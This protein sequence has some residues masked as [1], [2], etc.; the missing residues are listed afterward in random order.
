MSHIHTIM[1]W[2]TPI[3]FYGF[4][5]LM[6]LGLWAETSQARFTYEEDE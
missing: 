2:L 1:D 4:Y 3:V 5:L 6:W